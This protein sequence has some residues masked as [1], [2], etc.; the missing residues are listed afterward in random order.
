MLILHV[1]NFDSILENDSYK[2][3]KKTPKINSYSLLTFSITLINLNMIDK[4]MPV[5]YHHSIKHDLGQTKRAV[6]EQGV[7]KTTKIIKKR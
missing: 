1:F 2:F 6:E 5:V 3:F 7:V 4:M